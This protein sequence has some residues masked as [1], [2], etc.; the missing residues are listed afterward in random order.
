MLLQFPK[1]IDKHLFANVGNCPLKRTEAVALFTNGIHD[2][3]FPLPANPIQAMSN[4]A[5]VWV[6]IFV[7]AQTGH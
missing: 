5:I 4:G 7:F 6:E 2:Q 3:D 1:L